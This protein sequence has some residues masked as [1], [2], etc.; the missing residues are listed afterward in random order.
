MR[1]RCWVRAT[2]S[3][4]TE[5]VELAQL[6]LEHR[7]VA[8]HDGEL[9][10]ALGALGLACAARACP[11]CS[12]DSAS[13]ACAQRRRGAHGLGDRRLALATL[14]RFSREPLA[15][16]LLVAG[17]ALE[18]VGAVLEGAGALLAGA[19]RE[20]QL[21]LG[22]AGLAGHGLE[23]VALLGRRLVGEVALAARGLEPLE[24]GPRARS[25][26]PRGRVMASAMAFSVRSTS[27]RAARRVCPSEPSFSAIAAIRAS[28]SLSRS[29]AASTAS[30]SSARVASAPD[31]AE[32][33]L[34]AL[35]GGPGHGV[36][37]V[38]E[39]GLQ[40]E[41]ARRSRAAASDRAR[42]VDVAAAGHGGDAGV[43]ADE[44]SRAAEP[45]GTRAT[46]S[47]TCSTAGRT[48]SGHST[49]SRAQRASPGRPGHD[50]PVD[51][52]SPTRPRAG[53]PARRRRRGAASRAAAAASSEPT[54]SAS[55]ADPSA[56][57]T[58][59]SQTGLDRDE[60]GDGAE[61]LVALVGG[62][63]QRCRAVLAAAG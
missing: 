61:D 57:A 14:P 41:Q 12:A 29:R 42:G 47:S 13:S 43:G 20:T 36:L 15:G 49:T 48:D 34:L 26:R 1:R 10:V 54:A 8:A 11:A 3:R 62:G 7:D 50:A 18:R 30:A 23:A 52:R 39:R 21:G 35:A 6:G 4:C 22:R 59:F 55:A 2:S 31:D 46:R 56:A 40:L 44:R 51:A 25:G 60:R 19:Q 28:L 53:W 17:A 63:E 5:S 27:D 45:S 16:L 38:V 37:G 33:G 32:A 24:R 58:A 9:G